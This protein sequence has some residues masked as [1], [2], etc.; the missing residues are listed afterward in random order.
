M[1]CTDCKDRGLLCNPCPDWD[2]FFSWVSR[3]TVPTG[4]EEVLYLTSCP[5]E[6][7]QENEEE[8]AAR[9]KEIRWGR[10]GLWWELGENIGRRVGDGVS[11]AFCYRVGL[12]FIRQSKWWGNNRHSSSSLCQG[13]TVKRTTPHMLCP[14]KAFKAKHCLRVA[15]ALAKSYTR[16]YE[17]QTISWG[18]RDITEGIIPTLWQYVRHNKPESIP[19]GLFNRISLL[20]V[21][22]SVYPFLI[23]S[24]SP[25]LIS[26]IDRGIFSMQKECQQGDEPQDW[27]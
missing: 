1:N 16:H 14:T 18:R 26:L 2:I 6:N 9:N 24:A 25:L 13:Q 27:T 7:Q 10:K 17:Q 5:G 20:S 4:W 11:T 22:Y 21:L 23:T 19:T 15:Q 12:E 8:K 3:P